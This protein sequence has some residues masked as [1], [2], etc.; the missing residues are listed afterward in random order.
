MS[1]VLTTPDSSDRKPAPPGIRGAAHAL[2]AA[3]VGLSLLGSQYAEARAQS[4]DCLP[5]GSGFLQVVLSGVVQYDIGWDDED[6]T[7]GGMGSSDWIDVE[8]QQTQVLFQSVQF[9]GVPAG[10]SSPVDLMFN[11]QVEEGA[12]GVDLSV[13]VGINDHASGRYFATS[14][15]G[16]C[17]ADVTEQSLIDENPAFRRYRLVVNGSCAEPSVQYAGPGGAG[18]SEVTVGDFEFVGIAIW[19]GPRS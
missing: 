6:M 14:E 11:I 10:A 5:D 17:T 8:G 19:M 4:Q 12:T 18:A 15:W 3:L 1:V 16:G 13:K 7:C 2:A 9:Q